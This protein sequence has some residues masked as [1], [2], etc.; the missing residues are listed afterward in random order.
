[1]PTD[2]QLEIISHYEGRLIEL[3][4]NFNEKNTY[5][6]EGL[7]SIVNTLQELEKNP[8]L[9]AVILSSK[10]ETYFSNGL[11]PK[12]FLGATREQVHY[13]VSLLLKASQAFYF[14]PFPTVSLIQGHCMAAG[15]VFAIFSDYR[16]MIDK[17]A[18]I[19][20]S[21]ALIALNFPSFPARI[22]AE[23]VGHQLARDLLYTGKL[24][25]GEEAKLNKLVDFTFSKE[26]IREEALKFAKKLSSLPLGSAKGLKKSLINPKRIG[27]EKIMEWD[28]NEL[29]DTI[30]T[31]DAQEGFRSILES[32]KPKF[33]S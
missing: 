28:T 20:F 21:E 19:G 23:L 10:Q 29:V 31:E 3:K 16:F 26:I 2:S 24:L 14:F 11:E 7:S 18:R 15:A 6:V 1:M 32:R 13:A 25:K 33:N 12:M 8:K 30:L 27:I 5:D 17:G 9:R 22:L 4:M